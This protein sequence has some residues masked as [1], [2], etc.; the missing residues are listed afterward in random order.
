MASSQEEAFSDSEADGTTWGAG[1]RRGS[2]YFGRGVEA[3]YI[4]NERTGILHAAQVGSKRNDTRHVIIAQGQV[5]ST[6][7]GCE[8]TTPFIKVTWEVPDLAMT[9]RRNACTMA[10]EELTYLA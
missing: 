6:P 8:L 7:C 5:W 2:T 1:E 9:C 10:L 4:Y 3:P